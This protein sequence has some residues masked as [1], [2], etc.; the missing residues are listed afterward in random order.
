MPGGCWVLPAVCYAHF[1]C[2]PCPR[3]LYRA[4]TLP[5]TAGYYG[6]A[7]SARP[8]YPRLATAA[9]LPYCLDALPA[10]SC[11]CCC[12]LR[13]WILPTQVIAICLPRWF[14]VAFPARVAGFS[15]PARSSRLYHARLPDSNTGSPALVLYV[16]GLVT[17]AFSRLHAVHARL[18]LPTAHAVYALP[19]YPALPCPVYAYGWF[20]RFTGFVTFTHR[21]AHGLR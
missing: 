13:L 8:F 17:F 20:V 18:V 3:L 10:P 21:L 1:G 15:V 14:P 7:R 2:L 11:L 16:A 19:H 12:G 4:A 9:P 6:Y 5:V